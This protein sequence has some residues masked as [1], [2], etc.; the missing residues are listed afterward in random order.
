V[1]VAKRSGA[2]MSEA[3]IVSAVVGVFDGPGNFTA[4]MYGFSWDKS[5]LLFLCFPLFLSLVN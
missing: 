3:D 5:M 4:T 1:A 2:M